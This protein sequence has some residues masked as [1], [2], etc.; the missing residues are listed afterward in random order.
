MRMMVEAFPIIVFQRKME[1]T[2]RKI[3]EIIEGESFVNGVL[4]YRT[5]FR[6]VV[7]NNE[8]KDGKVNVEGHFERVERISDR[9]RDELIQNG[10]S[11]KE[12]DYF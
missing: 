10:L 3:T 9:L 7:D 6:Y 12:A 1:D 5:L 2:S 8:I 4:K 11:K